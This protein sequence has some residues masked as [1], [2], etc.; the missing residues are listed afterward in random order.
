MSAMYRD[1]AGGRWWASWADLAP[2]LEGTR[3]L[4]ASVL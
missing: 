1:W 3:G 2:I 4:L